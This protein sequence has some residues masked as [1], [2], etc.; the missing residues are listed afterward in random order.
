MALKNVLNSPLTSTV[1]QYFIQQMDDSNHDMMN[2]MTQQIV[3]TFNPMI[4]NTNNT[5]QV[6]AR[7]MGRI[8][9]VFGA[10]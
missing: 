1:M 7:H 10:P 8:S 9:D 5:Y 4:E 2:M 6:L 3:T